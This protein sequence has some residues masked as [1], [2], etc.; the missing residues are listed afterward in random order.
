MK[1]VILFI[2][3][4]VLFATSENVLGGGTPHTAMGKIYNAG[5]VEQPAD[6]DIIFNAL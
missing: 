6:G 3:I 1:R 5:G 2:L 4:F